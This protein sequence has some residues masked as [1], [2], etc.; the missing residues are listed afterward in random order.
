MANKITLRKSFQDGQGAGSSS[1]FVYDVDLDFNANVVETTINQIIDELNAIL[2]PNAAIAVDMLTIQD[3]TT[4]GGAQ[5]NGRIGA[6]S[7]SASL[8]PGNAVTVTAGQAIAASL[9]VTIGSPHAAQH[10]RRRDRAAL[11][12]PLPGGGPLDP[13]DRAGDPELARPL[14]VHRDGRCPERARATGGDLLG[15]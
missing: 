4:P 10:R 11:H 7:F 1:Y 15:R 2:G 9:R 6:H 14:R 3:G 13:V 8:G 12:Q 5:G